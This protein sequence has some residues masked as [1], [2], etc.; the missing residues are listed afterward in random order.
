MKVKERKSKSTR[1]SEKSSIMSKDT[2]KRTSK[3]A[4]KTIR[5]KRS[6]KIV[7]HS[8]NNLFKKVCKKRS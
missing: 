1:T 3:H 5:V 8:K 6:K 4:S 7:K 2:C